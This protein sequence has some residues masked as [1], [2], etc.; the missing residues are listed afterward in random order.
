MTET[1]LVLV[2]NNASDLT[3]P[4][5]IPCIATTPQLALNMARMASTGSDFFN[6][7]AEILIY[8]LEE[9]HDYTLAELQ[10]KRDTPQDTL[11]YRRWMNHPVCS[12]EP[13]FREE[14]KC[15]RFRLESGHPR[16][17]PAAA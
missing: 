17:E 7:G 9:N 15:E 4:A 14:F 6:F 12:D 1:Y 11:V 8:R 3:I 5:Q 10:Q 16:P 13:S 2:Q